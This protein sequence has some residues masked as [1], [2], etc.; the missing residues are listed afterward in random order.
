MT[1]A[2]SPASILHIDM[3]AFYAAVELLDHPELK[4]KPVVVGAP[5]NQRGVVSTAS[6]EARR[7]GIHSA[8]PSR[9]AGKL[10]PHATFLP[11]RMERYMEMSDRV[12]SIIESFSPVIEQ[13]S[14]DEAFVDVRGALR[15]WGDSVKLARALKDKIKSELGLTASVGVAPNKVLAKVASDLEKPD[16]LTVVPTEEKDIA[17]FLAPLSVTRIWG[18]GKV[19]AAR[20]RQFGI[21]TIGDLQQ[22]SHAGMESIV[23]EAMASHILSLAFGRD[24][25]PVVTEYEAKSISAEHTFDVDC[26]DA[27]TLRGKMIELTE[28]VGR[29]LRRSGKTARVAQI[30]IRYDDF[31]TFTRQRA[32]KPATSSDRDLIRAML[33]LY[34]AQKLERSVRLLGFGVAGFDET[35]AVAKSGY[36]F[37]EMNEA[38]GRAKDERLDRTLDQLRETFGDDAIRRGKWK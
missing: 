2:T 35:D 18:V 31:R 23:G 36:L 30:K 38:P 34:D 21:R 16:G 37:P 1:G 19:S 29:R 5:P 17:A 12:M 20:L 10:C 24:D 6:Y 33:E 32:L 7:F 4:G 26:D 25:R 28:H 11:V 9:T 22:R 13:V 8:M 14:V 27:P 3:D 15:R